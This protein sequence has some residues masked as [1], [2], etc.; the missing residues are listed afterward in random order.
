MY[1]V[2]R[3]VSGGEFEEVFSTREFEEEVS[4]FSTVQCLDDVR[5]FPGEKLIYCVRAVDTNSLAGV[6]SVPVEL[7][8]P[9]SFAVQLH[10]RCPV[11]QRTV[12]VS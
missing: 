11:A 2:Q 6:W 9:D 3:S 5:A 12:L 8:L 10:F 1:A 4:E 7:Q